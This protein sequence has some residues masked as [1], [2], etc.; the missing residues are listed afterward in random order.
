MARPRKTVTAEK[1]VEEKKEVIKTAEAQAEKAPAKRGRP[2]KKAVEAKA[3]AEKKVV[4]KKTAEKKTAPAE[5]KVAEKK[6]PAAKKTAEKKAAAKKSPAVKK[7]AEKK[8]P[9]AKKTAEKKTTGISVVLQYNDKEADIEQIK[10]KVTEAIRNSGNRVSKDL[11]IYIKPAENAAY[12]VN[13]DE[14]GK[15][16]L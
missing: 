2:P 7:T 6:A 12:Y 5:K 8:A 13:G 14:N 16:D 11:I 15:I 9:A 4:E 1:A 3:A 10:S